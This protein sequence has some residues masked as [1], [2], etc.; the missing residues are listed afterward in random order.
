ME[1]Q[2]SRLFPSKV[3]LQISDACNSRCVF[4]PRKGLE[5]RFPSGSMSIALLEQILAEV[6]WHGD[7]VVEMDVNLHCE[8]TLDPRL[9]YF[10]RRLAEHGHPPALITNGSRLH[11]HD[12]DDLVGHVSMIQ[13]SMHG[14]RE[15]ERRERYMPG[16]DHEQCYRNV[17]AVGRAIKRLGREVMLRVTDMF[18]PGPEEEA[19]RERWAELAGCGE[20]FVFVRPR[21]LQR[22][23]ALDLGVRA[24]P[25]VRCASLCGP[26]E[27]AGILW[28]G[29][30]VICSADWERRRSPGMI[31]REGSIEDLFN[32]Q[33]ANRLRWESSGEVDLPEDHI[34]RRC[35]A[36]PPLE[37]FKQDGAAVN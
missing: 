25:R 29:T 35:C 33:T 27:M 31:Y 3:F 7:R 24:G 36:V 12:L 9:G 26:H 23:G 37:A 22:D 16:L 6:D 4:C 19:Q 32:S 13:F 15:A 30:M 1:R 10:C 14:G 18:C 34:C 2:V 11:D 17:A 8:P 5:G 20:N 21:L 28:D